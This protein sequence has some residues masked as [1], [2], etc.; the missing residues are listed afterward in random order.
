[1][2]LGC[3]LCSK[4]YY[5]DVHYFQKSRNI[6]VFVETYC[7]LW[8][9]DTFSILGLLI[10]EKE[11]QW[12]QKTEIWLKS[13]SF[14]HIPQLTKIKGF[15]FFFFFLF[16]GGKSGLITHNQNLYVNKKMGKNLF[17]CCRNRFSRE[18]FSGLWLCW[19][20]AHI[21]HIFL[22]ESIFKT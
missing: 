22:G 15:L 21:V 13:H 5:Q 1:M 8:F 16:L 20:W 6:L 7:I 9:F 14:L 12:R 18:R 19:C 17:L 4:K 3:S 10:L 2:L 11:R